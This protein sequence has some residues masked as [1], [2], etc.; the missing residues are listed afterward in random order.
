[1]PATGNTGAEVDQQKMA[2]L[3]AIA[4]QGSQ[5]QQAF[6][7]EA[8]RRSAAQQAAVA[9]VAGQSKMSGIFKHRHALIG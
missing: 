3:T 2:L 9:S 6:Q 4:Q 5:G 8:A 1:M 7:A